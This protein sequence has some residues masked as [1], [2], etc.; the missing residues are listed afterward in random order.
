MKIARDTTLIPP[1]PIVRERLAT[2]I[3]EGRILRALLRVSLR[4]AEE[5]H[6]QTTATAIPEA[7]RRQGVA[8]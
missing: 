8:R 2:H 5:R 1:P 3:R 6:R 7:D 4:A